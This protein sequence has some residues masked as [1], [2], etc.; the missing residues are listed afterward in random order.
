MLSIDI[1]SI[2]YTTTIFFYLYIYK[3]AHFAHV[4]DN[5]RQKC[6]KMRIKSA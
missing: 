3:N 6:R 2:I 1:Y 5:Q 4:P